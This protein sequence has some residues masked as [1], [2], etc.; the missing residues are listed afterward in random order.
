MII[1]QARSRGFSHDLIPGPRLGG[2]GRPS[3]T[4][5]PTWEQWEH[6]KPNTFPEHAQ[7]AASRRQSLLACC[8]EHCQRTALKHPHICTDVQSM[9]YQYGSPSP[10]LGTH[11]FS[12]HSFFL[13]HSTR[14]QLAECLIN[15][16]P[17]LCHTFQEGRSWLMLVTANSPAPRTA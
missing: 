7:W 6:L 12:P 14:Q 4:C 2:P 10:A 1:L 5:L 8:L 9:I 15:H 16:V 17:Q 11:I 13:L 3:H